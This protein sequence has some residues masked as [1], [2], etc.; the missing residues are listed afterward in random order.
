[1][2]RIHSSDATPERSWQ[3]NIENQFHNARLSSSLLKSLTATI[4]LTLTVGCIPTQ[5]F[6]SKI[7]PTSEKNLISVNNCDLTS[8]KENNS[9]IS[10]VSQNA[11][12]TQCA[13][14][15][16]FSQAVR[17]ATKASQLAQSARTK[18]QWDKVA[19][20]WVQA[21]AWMQAVPPG[22][23]RR[24]FA[25]KKVA[26]YMRNL[27]YSQKQAASARSQYNPV[28]FNSDILDTQLEL[29]LSFVATVGPPD[30][31]IVGSSRALYGVDPQQL[32]QYLV[33]KGY[34]PLNI[35]NFSIN[36]A[37]ARVVDFQLRQLLSNNQLPKLII[38][39]DGV[40]AF[41]SG[42]VDRTYNSIV[43][44]EG[45]RKLLSGVRPQLP[46]AQSNFASTCYQFP[47]PYNVFAPPYS[48]FEISRGEAMEVSYSEQT[49]AVGLRVGDRSKQWEPGKETLLWELAATEGTHTNRG[50]TGVGNNS[51]ILYPDYFK[52]TQYSYKPLSQ[53]SSNLTSYPQYSTQPVQTVAIADVA[54]A[55]DANGFLPMDGRFNPSYYYQRRPYVAGL[56]DGDYAGFYL[57]GTQATA[58]TSVVNFTKSRNIPLVF[59]NLPLSDS[60]LDSVRWSAEEDFHQWMQSRARENGFTFLNFNLYQP[61]LAKNEYFFDPSHLN[62]YG[63]AA[64]A[65]YIAAST[66]ISWPR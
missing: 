15:D 40:R 48:P 54:N 19:Q 14:V 29:Y 18:Q 27:A 50:N 46:R 36:G 20:E 23:P 28:S 64:V 31:L 9:K 30:V 21:V 45:K 34:R 2:T 41:N 62:R 35:F 12:A 8:A 17:F 49:T 59:V 65:R 44:S 39:A 16:P 37:T 33:A 38:W 58:L 60:Y 32:Q 13:S 10:L 5:H 61:Q 47:K 24:A 57:G 22:N 56:Y 4:L 55:I 63:A 42:R 53:N 43:A 6:Q 3:Q 1:M 26:E 7:S 25:E 11:N 52:T 51:N 66:R